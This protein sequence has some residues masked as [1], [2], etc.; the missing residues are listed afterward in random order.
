MKKYV[1]L[2]GCILLFSAH[3]VNAQKIVSKF[4]EEYYKSIEWRNIGPFRGGRSAAVTGV[5][6]KANLFYF[7]AAGGGVWK[8]TDAGNTWSN[9]SDE[10]FGGSVGA[11]AV[12]ESDNNVMYVGNGEVTVRGNV[13]SGD[14]MWKSVNAGKSWEHIGLEK[15]RHIPRV[16]IHPK[17]ADIV[18]VAVLGDLYKPTSE[19]GIYKSI[20]GGKNWKKVLFANKNAGAVDLIID[21]TNPRVLYASTWNVRR[22][23][24]SLS[25]GGEG[26]A[27]WKSTDEGETWINISKNEGLPKGVWGISGVTV[28]PINSDIVWA[29]IENKDGGIY[30]STNAG[31]TWKLINSERKLR[32]RAWYYTRIY[33]DTQD[34]NIVYVMNVQYHQSKD[35]GKTFKTFN[36]PHGDH[37]DL[38][39]A[40]EDNQQ[41]I[42]ADDGGAQVSFDAGENWSSIMNQ[43]TSQFY[44]VVTDNHFPYRIYGAQQDNSTVR[45]LHRTDGRSIGES[46]W[47]STAG[48]E[49]AHIAVDPLNNDIVYGGSYGGLLTRIN[50]KTG[51]RRVINVWPDDPMGHGAEDFKYRFQW[52]YPIF[53]SPHNKKK[54]YTTSNHVHVTYNEGQSFEIIS[55][56]LTRN[57]PSTLKSSG[58]PITQ[59]NTG[60]EYYGTIFAAVESPF[61]KDLI[62][63]GSDDGLVYITKNGGKNWTNVTPKKMPEWMMINCIEV[64]PFT[65]GGAYIVGTRYKL[66]DYTPYIYKTEDYGKS[67]KLITNGIAGEHFT[68]ALRSDPNRKG[69]LYVGTEAGMYVS[70]DDGTNWSSFQLNLPIVPITDLAVKNNNLIAATQG[71]SFWIIDDLTPLHQLNKELISKDAFLYKPINSYRMGGSKRTSKTAGQ[72]HSGGV[73]IHYFVKNVEEKDTISLSIYENSGKHIK[74][75][76]TKPDTD[77][78]EEKLKVKKGANQFNWN[79]QYPDAEKIKGMILW[80]ASLRGPKALPGDYKVKLSKNG[81][82][83]SEQTFTLL[84]DPRSSATG[85]VLEAQFNFIIEIQEKLT[86]IH[87]TLKNITKIKGQVKQLKSSITDKEKNKKI[88]ELADKIVKDL[89]KYENNLYQTKSKSN[90]DPL[91]FPIKLNNKLAHLNALSSIGDFKPTDQS[92]AFKNEVI[93]LIDIELAKIYSIFEKD[94]KTLNQKVKQSD[95]NLINLN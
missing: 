14:G 10:F 83:V 81:I 52:N 71:R 21:P 53:F 68:R 41:M 42:I 72:N 34:E 51:E 38:W 49:S 5:P 79:M 17:N 76:S 3:K 60:V 94:V 1:L 73:N 46:D 37:H 13:S 23:P 74:T 64:D 40:P 88:I 80:W 9:I 75:F 12:S 89:T 30:K 26:S 32:Q 8:T 27:L 24:Y 33:A 25:S 28:S 20:D 6:N 87:K 77:Q 55:P 84:K 67:W 82:S 43:P 90:Q 85:E 65:A 35:G 62:W 4:S 31:K 18:F 48:G 7:G 54:L 66:G 39:I 86:E 22:T 29:L 92:V 91:N 15:S 70:F 44:R 45:I 61:E 58:G 63:T 69:L 59:D 47:E 93:K 36:A 50:H 19:R 57:D 78:K 16:R 2:V 56:D 95:I 11:I